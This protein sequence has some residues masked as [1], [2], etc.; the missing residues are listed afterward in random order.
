MGWLRLRPSTLIM[1]FVDIHTH[2]ERKG[3]VIVNRYPADF[4]PIEGYWYSVGIHPWYVS[5]ATLDADQQALAGI[6]ANPLVLAIG[7]AGLDLKAETDLNLQKK[8]F[9]SQIELSEQVQKPMILHVVH[10]FHE[11]LALHKEYAPKQ[12]W[13]IHGFRGK[14]ETAIQLLNQGFYLSVGEHFPVKALH[15][16]PLN[17]L[18]I[19]TDESQKPVDFLY[20]TIAAELDLPIEELSEAISQ[21]SSLFWA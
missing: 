20:G 12:P 1:T 7:E 4:S 6:I 18:F 13:I 9:R 3:K 17:R 16:I 15:V 2:F 19:E 21:N 10:A 14:P 11:V 5:E 8:A